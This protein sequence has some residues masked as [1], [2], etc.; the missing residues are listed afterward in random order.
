MHQ[1]N[2]S[3]A[4]LRVLITGV[5]GFIGSY[6]AKHFASL[7]YTV[8]GMDITAPPAVELVYFH[9]EGINKNSLQKVFKDFQPTVCIHCAGSASVPFSVTNPL[10][11]YEQN[12]YTTYQL[13]EALRL[14][15]PTCKFILLSSA[16]VYGN[17]QQLPITENSPTKP[18]SPYGTHKLMA[19]MACQE[20]TTLYNIPTA[21]LR[22]FSAYGNGL[23]KQVIWDI[24]EKTKSQIHISLKGKGDET[25]DFIHISDI[26]WAIG[27]VV[28]QGEHKATVY[29]LA[30]GNAI[31]IKNLVEMLLHTLSP[32]YQVSFDG[33]APMGSPLYWEADI[34]KLT[35]LGFS[36]QMT[37]QEG[38]Q[39]YVSWWHTIQ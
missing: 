9:C 34:S 16:A 19:E 1:I 14:Y 35:K 22:I 33:I 27:A 2:T 7:G 32:T 26:V 13:L 15:Q 5:S 6:V 30:S 36:P 31:S 39:Q 11:D 3:T 18:I 8:G 20:Y 29:N 12:T 10:F 37:L 21:I 24:C 28:E 38:I 17:P 4:S 25:R 23:R